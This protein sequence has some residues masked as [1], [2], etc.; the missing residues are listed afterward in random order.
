MKYYNLNL[1]IDNRLE[2][3]K[4]RIHLDT[5]LLFKH[6]DIRKTHD[7]KSGFYRLKLL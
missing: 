7:F 6:N 4:L 5:E 1:K 2:S 3:V